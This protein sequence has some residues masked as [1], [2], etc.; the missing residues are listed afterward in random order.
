MAGWY[1]TDWTSRLTITIDH[2]KVAETRAYP[3]LFTHDNVPEH[4]WSNVKNDGTDI[5]I[6]SSDG[7]TKIERDLVWISITD[8]VLVVRILA[9]LSS[10]VDDVFYM[11]YGNPDGAETNSTTAY[12]STLEMYIPCDEVE[13]GAPATL[14]DRTSNDNDMT[15]VS[16]VQLSDPGNVGYIMTCD[17]TSDYAW[18]A[19]SASLD[20]TNNLTAMLW[21]RG[22]DA[23][24]DIDERLFSKYK[25]S[26]GNRSWMMT[27][28]SANGARLRIL[29]SD[30]GTFNAGHRKDYTTS[31]TA[32]ENGAWH[33]LA[34]TFSSGTLKVYVDGVEDTSVTKTVD[35]AITSVFSSAAPVALAANGDLAERWG[36]GYLDEAKV[37]SEALSANAILTIFNNE[38]ATE[39]FYATSGTGTTAN[40][41]LNINRINGVLTAI[42]S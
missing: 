19:D 6:T 24:P 21:V 33:H 25:T 13:T 28:G 1:N 35:E 11:Y 3:V 36:T 27:S 22:S 40:I 30:D 20:I 8:S 17:G 2:T 12:P 7:E 39:D 9:T 41:Q 34:F 5:V 4:F 23:T 10:S 32:I 31:V 38:G 16:I 14:Y 29:I 18:A 37:W 26:D 15:G 42:P